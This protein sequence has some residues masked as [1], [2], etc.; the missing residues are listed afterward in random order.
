MK[1]T[2]LRI[3]NLLYSEFEGKVVKL[4]YITTAS[5]GYGKGNFHPLDGFK[6]IP[7]TEEWLLMLPEDEWEFVGFGTRTIYQHVKFKAIKIE[8]LPSDQVVVYFNDEPINYKDYLHQLQ[9]L[10]FDL[11]G[12][13]LINEES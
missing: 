11:T 9:N 2:E 1:E 3:G 10:F 7:L 12:E 6:P 5:A 4:N 8:Q 13:E